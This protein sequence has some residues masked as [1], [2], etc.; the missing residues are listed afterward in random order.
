MWAIFIVKEPFLDS[1]TYIA[2]PIIMD[3]AHFA[4]SQSS[5]VALSSR[6]TTVTKIRSYSTL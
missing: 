4:V 3:V 6:I 5:V 2:I 1:S